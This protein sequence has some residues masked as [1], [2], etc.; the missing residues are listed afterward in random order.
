MSRDDELVIHIGGMMGIRTENILMPSYFV[1]KG[2][3][4][5]Y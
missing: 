2:M 5:S 3:I 4:S 1:L